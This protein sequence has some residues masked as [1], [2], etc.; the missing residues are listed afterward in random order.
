MSINDA[1]GKI[2]SKINELSVEVKD[3][4]QA[5]RIDRDEIEAL[6]GEVRSLSQGSV[7]DD[8]YE[9]N[10]EDVE[11]VS[12]PAPVITASSPSNNTR[13]KSKSPASKIVLI[14]TSKVKEWF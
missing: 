2:I 10:V 13:S 5:R 4:K 14:D 12:A 9:E 3:I 1:F 11:L 6:R 7:D 8:D